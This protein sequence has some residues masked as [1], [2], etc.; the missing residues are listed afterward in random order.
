M[1]TVSDCLEEDALFNYLEF[2]YCSVQSRFGAT[3]YLLI[4]LLFLFVAIGITADDFLCPVLITISKSLKLSDNIAGVTFLAFG[5]GAPDIF[6]SLIGVNEDD[7]S[8]IIGE[9]FGAGIFVTTVV[10]GS[11]LLRTD[12]TIMKRPLL[13]DISFYLVTTGLVWG[14]LYNGSI[15][16]YNSLVYI[17]IYIVYVLVVVVSGYFYKTNLKK[18]QTTAAAARSMPQDRLEGKKKYQMQESEKGDNSKNK[19]IKLKTIMSKPPDDDE[20]VVLQKI[21]FRKYH[22]NP[23]RQRRFTI[24]QIG[25]DSNRTELPNDAKLASVYTLPQ[26]GD[27]SNFDDNNNDSNYANHQHFKAID[28]NNLNTRRKLA[29]ETIYTSPTIANLISFPN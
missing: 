6:S 14:I 25:D 9:L 22:T 15:H 2:A 13:R 8:L 26:A 5:N 20:G 12:F 3:A 7:S 4:W 17:A 18:A 29:I 28:M 23:L 24:Y 1:Q 11:I 27:N 10:V 19:K 21:I 16:L